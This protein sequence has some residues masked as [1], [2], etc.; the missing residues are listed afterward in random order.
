MAKTSNSDARKTLQELVDDIK[1]VFKK[2]S[3]TARERAWDALTSS[4]GKKEI[5]QLIKNP[6]KNVYG[7]NRWLSFKDWVEE[8]EKLITER[9]DK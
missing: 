3:R 4:R 7:V 1:R 9:E 5:D 8:K 6:S 2:Y